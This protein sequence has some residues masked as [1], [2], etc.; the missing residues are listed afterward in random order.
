MKPRKL[1]KSMLEHIPIPDV[2]NH[3]E[4]CP[5]GDIRVKRNRWICAALESAEKGRILREGKMRS[6]VGCM[7]FAH[8]LCQCLSCLAWMLTANMGLHVMHVVDSRSCVRV[9]GTMDPR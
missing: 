4:L 3:G 8:Q 5:G 2:Q 1:L 9:C 6:L 7:N